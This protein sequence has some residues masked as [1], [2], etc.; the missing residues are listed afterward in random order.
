MN[1]KSSRTAGTAVN[2]SGKVDGRK[3][4]LSLGN[5]VSVLLF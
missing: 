5:G 1:T 3:L 4:E 2:N